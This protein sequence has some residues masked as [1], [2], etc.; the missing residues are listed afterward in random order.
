MRALAWLCVVAGLVIGSI[1]V[2]YATYETTM[3]EEV[4]IQRELRSQNAARLR[5]L[6][7]DIDQKVRPAGVIVSPWPGVI[8]GAVVTSFGPLTRD[9]EAGASAR[10]GIGHFASLM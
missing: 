1:S 10:G 9:S 2:S 4:W 8:A 6:I 5:Q 3:R 7:H